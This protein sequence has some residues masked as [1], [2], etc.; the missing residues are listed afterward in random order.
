MY[1]RRVAQCIYKAKFCS[2]S[3]FSKSCFDFVWKGLKRSAFYSRLLIVGVHREKI[4]ERAFFGQKT[5]KKCVFGVQLSFYT[6]FSSLESKR[7][8]NSC[9]SYLVTLKVTVGMKK[10]LNSTVIGPILA[11]KG[12]FLAKIAHL[13]VLYHV[14]Y[15]KTQN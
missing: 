12:V 10:G 9:N 2:I 13:T 14:G 1:A 8:Q 7:T 15:Q 11:K 4:V 3:E 6:K 5:A